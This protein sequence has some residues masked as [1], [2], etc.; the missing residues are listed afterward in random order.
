MLVSPDT[1]VG[2]CLFYFPA[3]DPTRA[4]ALCLKNSALAT[5]AVGVLASP[6][7]VP[8]VREPGH[9]RVLPEAVTAAV[10]S[11]WGQWPQR[12]LLQGSIQEVILPVAPLRP[13]V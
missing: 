2:I 10:S 9:G 3:Q 7:V 6:W 13:A 8:H 12:L 5:E 11:F 4:S 1:M